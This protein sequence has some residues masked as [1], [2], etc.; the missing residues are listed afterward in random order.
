M[1]LQILNSVVYSKLEVNLCKGLHYYGKHI[2][3]ISEAV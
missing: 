1:Q 3:Q 2:V